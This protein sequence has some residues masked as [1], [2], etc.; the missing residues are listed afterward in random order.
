MLKIYLFYICQYKLSH[1]NCQVLH[2][3]CLFSGLLGECDTSMPSL[4]ITTIGQMITKLSDSGLDYTYN[5]VHRLDT[6]CHNSPYFP[7]QAGV[8]V[9]YTDACVLWHIP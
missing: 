9:L 8:V 3:N 6:Q 1:R 5:I 2:N 7:E 4:Y